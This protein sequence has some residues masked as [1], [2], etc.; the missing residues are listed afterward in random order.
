MPIAEAQMVTPSRKVKRKVV[1][2]VVVVRVDSS[3]ACSVVDLLEEVASTASKDPA[4]GDVD[5]D[6]SLIALGKVR[7]VLVEHLDSVLL[8]PGQQEFGVFGGTDRLRESQVDVNPAFLC[9]RSNHERLQSEIFW[10]IPLFNLQKIALDEFAIDPGEPWLKEL[11][12]LKGADLALNEHLGG[13]YL[14]SCLASQTLEI[15]DGTAQVFG[16]IIVQ[17]HRFVQLSERNRH[18]R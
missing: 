17:D 18:G 10:Q 1:D 7:R 12:Q 13:N 5:Q 3:C 6:V 15:V 8:K 14:V 11:E 4:S 2:V 16:E 9:Q